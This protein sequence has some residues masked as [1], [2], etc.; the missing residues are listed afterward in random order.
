M[1]D[2]NA[3]GRQ[4]DQNQPNAQSMT[5][6]ERVEHFFHT[7]FGKWGRI[8]TNHT[9]KVFWLSILF[10]IALS[11]GMAMRANFEDE[12]L[13][14]TPADNNSL[15]SRNKGN[16]LFPS[17]GRFIGLIAEVKEPEAASII[18]LKALSE[19]KKFTELMLE[20][21]VEINGTNVKYTDVCTKVGGECLAFE[22]LLQF[23]YEF[24]P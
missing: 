19:V 13:V 10:F 6:Q 4:G 3:E 15:R 20:S 18:S 8:L 1:S 17:K 24:T 9:C 16:A 2:T 23:G 14:W 22:S 7:I 21:E 12:S 5:I 11:S